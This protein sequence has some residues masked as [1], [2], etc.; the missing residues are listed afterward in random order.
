MI[1]PFLDARHFILQANTKTDEQE[2]R[3][4]LDKAND[5]ITNAIH[6]A[7]MD[8]KVTS[9]TFVDCTKNILNPLSINKTKY[10]K[11]IASDL[12]ILSKHIGVKLQLLNYIADYDT[13]KIV[14]D[15][16]KY[17]MNNFFNNKVYKNMTVPELLQEHSN[18]KNN[19]DY[20]FNLS[21]YMKKTN[22]TEQLQDKEIIYISVEDSN[23]E[24]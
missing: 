21:N 2:K 20:W 11:Y 17:Q 23:E 9:E 15:D 3:V 19:K 24:K 14:Y 4:L 5:K 1:V 18:Y 12:Q 8:L 22:K 6:S 7:Y 10:M 16:Y 13:A